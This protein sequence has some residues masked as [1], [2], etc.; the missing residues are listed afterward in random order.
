MIFGEDDP[1]SLG[2]PVPG[3]MVEIR[4]SSGQVV[5]RG[6]V[7]EIWLRAIGQRSMRPPGA[8]GIIQ[9][10]EWIS[11]GDLGTLAEDGSVHL[12]GRLKDVINVSGM[13][14]SPV[15]IERAL[16]EHPEVQAAAAFPVPDPLLGEVTGAA[17]VARSHSAAPTTTDLLAF[18]AERLHKAEI[19]RVVLVLEQLPLNS[20]GKV[21]K[22]SLSAMAKSNVPT[23][24]ACGCRILPVATFGGTEV[25][26]GV[27]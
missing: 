7:G 18:A 19:P 14:I 5:P 25:T 9:P 20:A 6:N 3:T 12:F 23:S 10:D 21:D 16:Q 13:K 11:S 22:R 17:I 4:D 1:S 26:E 15:L 24:R 2:R 8:S 27:Y